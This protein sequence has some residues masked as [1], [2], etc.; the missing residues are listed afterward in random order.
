MF[1]NPRCG[2]VFRVKG[3]VRQD[4]GWLEVNAT[5]SDTAMQPVDNG[6]DIIIVIGENLNEENI[7]AAVHGKE[8]ETA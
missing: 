7:R 2:N 6:Q 1:E 8:G 4:G 5:R 3:F